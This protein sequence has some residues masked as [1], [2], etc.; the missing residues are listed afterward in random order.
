M[1]SH[2]EAALLLLAR[3]LLFCPAQGLPAMQDSFRAAYRLR[4][5]SRRFVSCQ[6]RELSSTATALSRLQHSQRVD[7]SQHLAEIPW[8]SE[9]AGR[10]ESR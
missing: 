5:G 2:F 1:E 4:E 7:F 9:D 10:R 3:L 6:G 8:W